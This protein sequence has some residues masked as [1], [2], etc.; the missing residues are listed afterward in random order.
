MQS[1]LQSL[2]GTLSENDSPP[3]RKPPRFQ[4]FGRPRQTWADLN[5]TYSRRQPPGLIGLDELVPDDTDEF[6]SD[7]ALSRHGL[8]LR[9]EI[10]AAQEG[11]QTGR[12]L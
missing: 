4:I 11:E 8:R 10:V 7:A 2:R 9:R 6:E 12:A 3:P 5:Q 1:Q